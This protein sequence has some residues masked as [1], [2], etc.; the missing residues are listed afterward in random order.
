MATA[1]DDIRPTQR[2]LGEIENPAFKHDLDLSDRYR[3]YS[4]EMLRLSLAE[5]AAIRFLISNIL[6]SAVPKVPIAAQQRVALSVT[7]PI[8]SGFADASLVCL[9]LSSAASLAHHYTATDSLTA[10]NTR[11]GGCAPC[12]Q[13]RAVSSERASRGRGPSYLRAGSP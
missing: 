7:A 8:F 4:A 13:T 6:L 1:R 10:T 2:E 9:G 3:N 11:R 12:D 5:I